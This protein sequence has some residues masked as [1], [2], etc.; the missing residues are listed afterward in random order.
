MKKKLLIYSIA[1]FTLFSCNNEKKEINTDQ[2]IYLG[3]DIITMEGDTPE[4]VEA[5]VREKDK[6]VFVGNKADALKQYA[7]AEQYDLKGKTMLPG[8]IDPHGHFMSAMLMVTQVNCA[9]P[10]M[11]DVTDIASMIAKL[12]D[13][14]KQKNLKDGE[15]IVGWGYDQDLL[16]EK[17]HIT[18]LDLDKAFPNNKV[19]I[20]HISMH[21]GV[22]N[23]KALEWA[24]LDENSKTPEGGVIARLP[25]TNEPAGLLMEMAYMPVFDKLP[26]PSEDEMMDLVEPAQMLYTSNGYTHAVEGFTHI[27]DMNTLKRAAKEGRIF[28]DIASLPGFNEMDKWLNNPEYKFGEYNNRLKFQGGK[29]TLDGSPQG[30]TAYMAE[31]Y[32]VPGPNGEKNWVGNTSIPREKLAELAKTMV[33]NDVQIMFH[34]NGDGAIEDA[35]YAI[36]SAGIKADQDKR[37]IIIHSQFQ[38]PEHLLKYVEIGISPTYFTNHTFYWGDVHIRNV[39]LKKASFISPIKAANDLGLITSNHTDFNVTLLDPFFVMWTSMKRETRSGKILGSE[40]II[41][42]YTALQQI[43]TGAAYQFFEENRK[44]KIKEGLLAD[45]VIIS[46][47]PLKLSNVDDVKE[48][49]VLQTIKE[50]DTVFKAK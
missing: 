7:N 14:K 22:L 49:K 35:I 50:G 48:I 30:L 1:I 42:A 20:I 33:D 46:N 31:P 44:G 39:G 24:N 10:P 21:G 5:V 34:A 23:S 3:G 38:K 26:Q 9:S 47:N 4:Y 40:Q 28:I 32:N 13:F 8:F 45:F 27:K 6:I 37:P 36:E 25:G 12:Q 16:K 17:R 43:T 18:K 11:G 15:W 41:D 19:L 29:F 2:T